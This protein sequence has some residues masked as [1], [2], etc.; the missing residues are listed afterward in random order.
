MSDS[1]VVHILLQTKIFEDQSQNRRCT[2]DDHG[3][4]IRIIFIHEVNI[5]CYYVF[6]IQFTEVFVC[7]EVH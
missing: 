3:I 4:I 1:V 7:E 6:N 5:S 2:E